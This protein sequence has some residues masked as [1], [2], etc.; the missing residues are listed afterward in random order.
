M[1]YA[2]RAGHNEI[3]RGSIGIVDEV[4][5]DRKIFAASKKYLSQVDSFTDCTPY[6]NPSNSS[7]DLNYGISK[8]NN[9]GALLFYSTHLNNAY[10]SYNGALGCEVIVY[11]RN[12]TI[13]IAAAKRILANLEALGFKNRGIKYMVDGRQLGELMHTKMSALIVECFFVEATEDIK[14]YNKVGAE[15]IGFAI[16]SGID[17]R[18]TRQHTITI[19]PYY[20]RIV[21]GG[22]NDL[23]KLSHAINTY[24]KGINI[25]LSWKNENYYLETGD[26]NS[27]E[28]ANN[29]AKKF[30]H[31][32][33]Y[34]EIKTVQYQ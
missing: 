31:D 6:H 19:K 10:N 12:S 34:Y 8:A 5:E 9:S 25:Y 3:C 7:E 24:F 28:E 26:F 17:P 1:S 14:V 30:S 27:R 15:A 29:Y 11:H 13:A 4:T 32:K 20:Y 2:G 21:T 22:F 18:V 33:Y 16:A 23:D